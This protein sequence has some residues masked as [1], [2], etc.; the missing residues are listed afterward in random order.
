ME[1]NWTTLFVAFGTAAGTAFGLAVPVGF[2][3]ARRL[4][5]DVNSSTSLREGVA[6][7]DKKLLE[8]THRDVKQ[9]LEALVRRH[10]VTGRLV[11]QAT[12]RA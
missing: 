11:P 8:E 1:S 7:S 4:A 6:D 3:L 9:L 2:R 10:P 5:P 12:D